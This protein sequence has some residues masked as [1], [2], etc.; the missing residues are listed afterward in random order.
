MG[1]EGNSLRNKSLYK[2]ELYLLKVMP[3]LIAAIY[4][5]NTVLSYKELGW[6]KKDLDKFIKDCKR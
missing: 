3:M 2:I 1:V 5:I 6:F 4:L